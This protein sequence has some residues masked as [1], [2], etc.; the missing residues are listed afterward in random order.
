MQKI[1]NCPFCRSRA[2]YQTDKKEWNMVIC[3]GCNISLS[4]KYNDLIPEKIQKE[5]LIRAWNQKR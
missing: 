1:R 5:T 3:S 2:Y 4:A